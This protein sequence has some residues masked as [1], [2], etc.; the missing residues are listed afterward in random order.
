MTGLRHRRR[1][2]RASRSSTLARSSR[3]ASRRPRFR[4]CRHRRA[5][6]RP[7]HPSCRPRIPPPRQPRHPLAPIATPVGEVVPVPGAGQSLLGVIEGL[8]IPP[9][10]ATPPYRFRV[11]IAC[12]VHFYSASG[13]VRVLATI[14]DSAGRQFTEDLRQLLEVGP[15]DAGRWLIAPIEL[16]VVEPG[17]YWLEGSIDWEQATPNPIHIPE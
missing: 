8:L 3:S 11:T 7:D 16:R 13:A 10:P 6:H 15:R 14:K 1:S 4:P 12:L 17:V 9:P 5:R 2:S